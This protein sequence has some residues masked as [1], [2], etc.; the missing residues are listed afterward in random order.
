MLRKNVIVER[1]EGTKIY[2]QRDCR[3]V[4]HVTGKEYKKDKQYVV[5][6]RVCIYLML[7]T[8]AAVLV[9]HFRN[10]KQIADGKE[11]KINFNREDL[12]YKF[13]NIFK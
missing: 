6:S 10:L 13:D 1:P 11:E 4:Y 2:N 7:L 8:G 9:R 5:E 3:Y 12:T